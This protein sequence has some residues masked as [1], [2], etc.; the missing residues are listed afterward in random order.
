MSP[1]DSVAAD[2]GFIDVNTVFGPEHGI[3]R[4]ADAPLSLLVEERRRHGVRLA[5]ASS[6]VAAWADPWGGNRAAV[7]AAADPANGLGAIAVVAPRETEAARRVA[8]AERLGVLGYR[9]E[10]WIGGSV[11]MDGL[12]RAI[13]DTG[14]PVLVPLGSDWRSGVGFASAIGAATAGLGIPVILLGAHYTNIVDTLAAARRYEHLHI[15]TSALAHFRAVATAVATI[16]ADRVLL[17]T[18]SP[19]RAGASAI[20][21]VLLA[22]IPDDAK[23]AI[24]A[25][26]AGRLF[27]LAASSVD[28]TPP[29][30]PERAWDAHTHYGPFDQD[31]PQVADADLLDALLDPAE[32]VAVA[33]SAVAIYADPAA[34]NAQAVAAAAGNGR[35]LSYVVADP[36][37]L[38][39]TEDQLRR[40]LRLHGVVGVKVHGNVL[41]L[42][43]A[44]RTMG[45]LFELLARFGRPVKIHNEG[46]DW[47]PA[48]G[49][50]AR[51]HPKLPIVIAH[52]GLGTPSVDAGRLAATHDNVYLELSS[53]FARL[54]EVRRAVAAAPIE[55]LLWGSDVPLLDPR[56]VFGTYEDACIPRDAWQRVFWRNAAEL[57]GR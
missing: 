52:A 36:H 40:H 16:G 1:A 29:V 5:L 15:E 23:R 17:G 30:L 13:A 53:S 50:I 34:G 3:G 55:R 38:A 9:L 20:D 41:G 31:V 14:R 49:E 19:E 56:F 24:L 26:N 7:D 43:T 2:R 46:A 22:D 47:A 45:D 42:P 21:A 32:D 44:N 12:L 33:S 4:A 8:D 57:Y 11:A 54:A 27:G 51:A 6:L 25:G 18:G 35:Q 39:F 28:L 48:L 37:D 10:G